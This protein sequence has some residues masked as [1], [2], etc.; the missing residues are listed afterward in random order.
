MY[1]YTLQA[2][3]HTDMEW[4]L[5]S[6]ILECLVRPGPARDSSGP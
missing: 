2:H 4:T 5:R 1:T 3:K 6:R